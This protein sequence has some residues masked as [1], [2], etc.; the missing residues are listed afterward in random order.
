MKEF[1]RTVRIAWVVFWEPLVTA[2]RWLGKF[3]FRACCDNPKLTWTDGVGIAVSTC[4]NCGNVKTY[5][6]PL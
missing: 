5:T 3:C 6:I 1:F 4:S 2:V